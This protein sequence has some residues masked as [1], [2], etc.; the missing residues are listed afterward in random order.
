MKSHQQNAV[1]RTILRAVDVI[2]SM[3]LGLSI[4]WDK[5]P[6]RKAT[7]IDWR[8]GWFF[9]ACFPICMLAF[10]GNPSFPSILDV[11]DRYSTIWLYVGFIGFAMIGAA[12]LM[13]I[14]P[15]VPLY[16]S[17]PVALTAWIYTVWLV[18]FHSERI[19]HL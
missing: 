6:F 14:G 10:G 5:E 2:V 9:V 11:A 13:K 18:G 7:R 15:K 4:R 12:V 3:F 19:I 8:V 1:L 17:I 16:L